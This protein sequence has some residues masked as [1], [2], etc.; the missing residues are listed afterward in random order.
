MTTKAMYSAMINSPGTELTSNITAAAT[1]ITVVNGSTLPPAPN[2]ATIGTDETAETIRY[3]AINGNV[4]TVERGFQ[5]AA[6]SWS[7]GAKVAR[8]YTAYDHDTFK[9]NIEEISKQL[10]TVQLTKTIGPGAN[11]INADQASALDMTVY[12]ASR[13]NLL[14]DNGTLKDSNSDGLADGF[15]KGSTLI[16]YSF[17]NG[18]QRL[19]SLT[20]STA[21][22]RYVAK[23]GISVKAG[24]KYV[25]IADIVT[26]GVAPANLLVSMGTGNINGAAS[27]QSTENKTHFVK[28]YATVDADNANVA[29]YNRITA[30]QD[31]WVQFKD[32]DFYEVDD[33]IYNAIGT[34]I[35]ESNIRDYFPHVDGRKHVQG[36]VITN[37]GKNNFD[38]EIVQVNKASFSKLGVNSLEVTSETTTFCR[39]DSSRIPVLPNTNYT[40]SAV[41]TNVSGADIPRLS[42]RKGSNPGVSIF[43]NLEGE[44]LTSLTFNTANETEVVLYFYGNLS[45]GTVQKKRFEKVQLE[46]GSVATPFE[47]REDQRILLPVTLGEVGGVRDSVDVRGTEATLTKRVEKDY[48]VDG[49]LSP[50]FQ[51]NHTGYKRVKL[52]LPTSYANDNGRLVK[53]NGVSMKQDNVNNASN[54]PDTFRV[55]SAYNGLVFSIAGS[56]SG[57]VDTIEPT[58]SAMKALLNGWKANANNG[59]AYTSWTSILDGSVPT[60]NTVAWVAANKAPNW[61]G[62][63][64]LDYALATPVISKVTDADGAISLH[65]GGNMITVESGVVIR[66]KANPVAGTNFY[67]INYTG[68]TPPSNLKYKNSRI[69]AVYKGA[70]LDPSW[71]IINDTFYAYGKQ[72][73]QMP[74]EKYDSTKEYFVTYLLLDKYALSANV[75]QVDVQYKAGLNGTVSDNVNNIA[76]LITENDAQ[77]YAEMYIQAMAENNAKDLKDHKASLSA[78]D[79]TAITNSDTANFPA[80]PKLSD[81]LAY[82]KSLANNLK[83]KVAGA[84]GAP[85]TATDTADQMETKINTIK[86]TAAT[87]LTAKGVTASAS[88][89]MTS[90][91]NKIAQIIRGQGNATA[92]DVLS[93]KSFTGDS[94][95]VQTGTMPNLTGIRIAT[96]ASR[97]PDGAL[98]VYPEQGY[99]K[100]GPGDGEIKVNTAQLQQ[101]EGTFAAR[102]IVVG[103]T[104]FGLAGTAK[105]GPEYST[106]LESSQSQTSNKN[107]NPI[108]F[109]IVRQV[110]PIGNVSINGYGEVEIIA[111]VNST[112]TPSQLDVTLTRA[113]DFTNVRYIVFSFSTGYSGVSDGNATFQFGLKSSMT[114]GHGNMVKKYSSYLNSSKTNDYANFV[115]FN[116]SD[117]IGMHY[118]AC[119]NDLVINVAGYTNQMTTKLKTIYLI[120]E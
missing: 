57:W 41:L 86:T 51:S 35:T 53:Y 45:T 115:Y 40:I 67:N 27:S 37:R 30:G 106:L 31:G 26:D 59:S 66:E 65:P 73:A 75:T 8:Y 9:G 90:L 14:G 24:K 29:C 110:A 1:S 70:S 97:W 58:S 43:N 84:I 50:Y 111:T 119:D 77:N 81:V 78:H 46:L 18:Y 38:G 5:G 85:L 16:N 34:T 39:A 52:S 47:P 11:L 64:A 36:V 92:A 62:F 44:G 61:I 113:I 56:E 103:T 94:G 32:V 20:T 48:L 7:A 12:G 108:P 120:C 83:S 87:N 72:I 118:V 22:D 109:T 21:A 112:T 17:V 42:I 107:I 33:A 102:N 13:T 4:L 69:L 76:R 117:I 80:M 98:A 88:E 6:K 10:D 55:N 74:K 116:V 82:L 54:E 93:P 23:F 71:S 25:F 2:L 79:T 19:T 105:Q 96:G 114:A 89:T 3:T 68:T 91:V 104:I 28:V 60:T 15:N 101:A 49:S 63:A 95:V 99:Q 100:G